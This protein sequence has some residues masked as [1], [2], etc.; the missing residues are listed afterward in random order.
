MSVSLLI[1]KDIKDGNMGAFETLFR[2]YYEPLCRYSYLFVESMETAEEIVGDLFYTLW[3]ERQK[4]QIF[5]SVNGYLY[6]AVKNKSLQYLEQKRVREDYRKIYIEHAVVETSTPQEDL[7]Y[8]ELEQQ[9]AQAL[10]HL[11]ERRQKIFHKHRVEGK[12]YN[13]IAQELQISVK[14]VEA[15]MTKALRELRDKYNSLQKSNN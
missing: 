11:P 13:E 6:R 10:A 4:L 15:E 14:T 12:K 2:A 8:K 5:T 3:K 7:E 1:F 9:I